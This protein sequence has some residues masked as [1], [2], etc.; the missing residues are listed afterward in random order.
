MYQVS[1][2][3]AIWIHVSRC[4]PP[5]ISTS[6]KRPERAEEVDHS[7][8]REVNQPMRHIIIHSARKRRRS[9]HVL[10]PTRT[11][12]PPKPVHT[13]QAPCLIWS[14]FNLPPTGRKQSNHQ[15]INTWL[16]ECFPLTTYSNLTYTPRTHQPSTRL[17][18]AGYPPGT[19]QQRG[20]PGI[21]MMNLAD[22]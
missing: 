3:Q 22:W 11:T 20:S 7:R 6:C 19:C 18:L 9:R 12:H 1:R 10:I 8:N 4:R 17:R 5:D 2:R 14:R 21:D 13:A 15:E 16:T